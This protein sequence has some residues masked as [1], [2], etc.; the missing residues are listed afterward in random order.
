M[1]KCSAGSNTNARPPD[2]LQGNWYLKGQSSTLMAK[3][4][5]NIVCSRSHHFSRRA[6]GFCRSSLPIPTWIGDVL[7]GLQH[8]KTS[9]HKNRLQSLE[10]IT[11]LFLNDFS[12]LHALLAYFSFTTR[13]VTS[14]HTIGAGRKASLATFMFFRYSITWSCTEKKVLEWPF[15]L[16]LILLFLCLSGSW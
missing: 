4:T 15:S 11:R 2:R 6:T 7:D 5:W 13:V 12:Y 10:I 8:I 3:T 1:Q 14:L 16:V 9:Q